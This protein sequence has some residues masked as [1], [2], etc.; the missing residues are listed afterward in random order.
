MLGVRCW[1]FELAARNQSS[2]IKTFSTCLDSA[3]VYS[4]M[5]AVMYSSQ[6]G[7]FTMKVGYKFALCTRHSGIA[8]PEL[9]LCNLQCANY[10][11]WKLE[12]DRWILFFFSFFRTRFSPWE[13]WSEK[14]LEPI[15]LIVRELDKITHFCFAFHNSVRCAL[16]FTKKEKELDTFP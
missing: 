14:F 11:L 10:N 6:Q 3:E 2:N 5:C 9:K 7:P 16:S 1:M 8:G 4:V 15:N 12:D 13:K